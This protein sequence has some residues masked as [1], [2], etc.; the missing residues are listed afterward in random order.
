MDRS[1]QPRKRSTLS[2]HKIDRST[3]FTL[4]YRQSSFSAKRPI[5][6]RKHQFA[7][8][9]IGEQN[10]ATSS[11]AQGERKGDNVSRSSSSSSSSSDSSSS[12]SDSDSDS[13]STSGSNAGHSPRT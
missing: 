8:Q 3:D 5:D 11:P 1:D 2:H 13:T 4:S 6:L 9:L 12:S 7:L 10:D